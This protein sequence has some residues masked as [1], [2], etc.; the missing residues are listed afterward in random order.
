MHTRDQIYAK[1][2]YD[3]VKQVQGWKEAERNRY[4]AL[5]HKLPV[6]IRTAGLVQA[7]TFLDAKAKDE[8]EKQGQQSPN[9]YR[10][11]LTDLAQTMKKD[12]KDALLERAREAELTEYTLLTRQ[13]LAVLLWYKRFAQSLLDVTDAQ[14]AG[15]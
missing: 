5:A 14:A 3:H 2:A 12:T 11:L 7:L 15:D 4:G 1:D 13:A 10:Q 9:A 6:L 8:Q